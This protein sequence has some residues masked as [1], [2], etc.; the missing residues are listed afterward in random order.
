MDSCVMLQ[1]SRGARRARR[2][3]AN[4]TALAQLR[5]EARRL[6]ADMRQRAGLLAVVI[7]ASNS[8]WSAGCA[9]LV[10][11]RK[12]IVTVTSE[13]AGAE[14]LIDGHQVAVTPAQLEF[15]R[16]RTNLVLR[17]EKPGFES[18]QI[19][20]K[21][22]TSAWLVADVAAGLDPFACQGLN[23]PSRCPLAMAEGL[24]FFL[25]IDY[26]TG[27]AFTLPKAIHA[28]LAPTSPR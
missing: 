5:A 24:A 27:A 1:S 22:G 14:I 21:R 28:T 26:L 3:D 18:Q 15:S 17:F 2:P 25:G 4:R 23:S 12:Q 7:L 8:A 11:G 13:P 10:H 20:L 19:A 6:A 9:S 16:R